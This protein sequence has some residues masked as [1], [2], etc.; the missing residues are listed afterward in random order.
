MIQTDI[1][2]SENKNFSSLSSQP[3]PITWTNTSFTPFHSI[4]RQRIT[5]PNNIHDSTS[6]SDT[7]TLSPTHDNNTEDDNIDWEFV[8]KQLETVR[9]EIKK[10]GN[11]FLFFLTE[12]TNVGR[13]YSD[14]I[15]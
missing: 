9:L 5:V 12:I 11:Y 3:Q 13:F 4:D 14:T 2:S 10:R 1:T 8:T 15:R 7:R 6:D